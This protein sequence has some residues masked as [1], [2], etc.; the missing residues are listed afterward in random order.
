MDPRPASPPTIAPILPGSAT[1]TSPPMPKA[2]LTWAR[3]DKG[4]FAVWATPADRG[5]CVQA[6]PFYVGKESKSRIEWHLSI[7][8]EASGLL[9]VRMRQG[10]GSPILN[11]PKDR[12]A[13]GLLL[14]D[15]LALEVDWATERPDVAANDVTLIDAAV[16]LRL[17]AIPEW[18]AWRIGVGG[19]PECEWHRTAEGAQAW[20]CRH[21]RADGWWMVEE[22]KVPPPWPYYKVEIRGP[23]DFLGIARGD[24]PKGCVSAVWEAW[25]VRRSSTPGNPAPEWTGDGR[26]DADRVRTLAWQPVEHWPTAPTGEQQVGPASAIAAGHIEI[27]GEPA[28]F[29]PTRAG[30]LLASREAVA[31]RLSKPRDL[32]RT[33][34]ALAEFRATRTTWRRGDYNRRDEHH[35]HAERFGAWLHLLACIAR[36]RAAGVRFELPNRPNYT[37]DRQRIISHEAG[38]VCLEVDTA[39]ARE[40]LTFRAVPVVPWAEGSALVPAMKPSRDPE[41]MWESTLEKHRACD[42]AENYAAEMRRIGG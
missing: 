28:V 15:I 30:L 34:D 23:V 6:V 16:A 3:T 11:N 7:L 32:Q 5:L 38:V 4:W 18:R 29:V 41:D 12:K 37:P 14:T 27:K 26:A 1:P 36:D 39:A 8:H 19:K 2:R 33:R 22:W 42:W 10:G 13:I 17:P 9:L 40:W 31:G 21:G 25:G 35:V 24:L 20:A